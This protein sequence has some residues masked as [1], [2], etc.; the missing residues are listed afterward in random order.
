MLFTLLEFPRVFAGGVFVKLED[1]DTF[2][3]VLC[4]WP[5]PRNPAARDRKR[6]L[7]VD[8]HA[9]VNGEARLYEMQTVHYWR[10]CGR[11]WTVALNEAAV[12]KRV[13]QLPDERPEDIIDT[14]RDVLGTPRGPVGSLQQGLLTFPQGFMGVA[15]RDL[16]LRQDTHSLVTRL[17]KN[18]AEM[19]TPRWMGIVGPPSP[20]Q[21][22]STLARLACDQSNSN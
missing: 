8:L 16:R 13:A 7:T 4:H 17:T 2:G 20:V 21:A 5:G 6:V 1:A 15:I 10:R 14:D 11:G 12:E 22:Q 19:G 18:T 9:E 3:S